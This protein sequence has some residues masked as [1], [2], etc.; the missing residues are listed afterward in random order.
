MSSA[1]DDPRR[2][3]ASTVGDTT[4]TSVLEQLATAGF[5]EDLRPAPPPGSLHCGA[6]G[7]V[8]SIETFGDVWARRLEGA[9]DPDDMVLVVAARCPVCGHGGSVVLGFGPASSPEDAAIVAEIPAH[10]VHVADRDT[11][12][13]V[14]GTNRTS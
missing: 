12:P 11:N 10:A 3:I 13:P 14:D 9:S 2:G 6:C 8:S 5:G 7:S 1:P 4:T